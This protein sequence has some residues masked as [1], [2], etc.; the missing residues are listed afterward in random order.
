MVSF[1]QEGLI[2]MTTTFGLM[3]KEDLV[4]EFVRR[5]PKQNLRARFP[6]MAAFHFCTVACVAIFCLNLAH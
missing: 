4:T 2:A 6:T 5:T 3:S 1:A